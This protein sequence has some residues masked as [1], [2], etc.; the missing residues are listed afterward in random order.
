MPLVRSLNKF[1]YTCMVLSTLISS[2]YAQSTPPTE[3]LIADLTEIRARGVL[4]VLVEQDRNTYFVVRNQ[5]VGLENARI[6]AFVDFLNSQAPE[7]TPPMRLEIIPLPSGVLLEALA[8]GQ[9]DLAVS[10]TPLAISSQPNLVA[11]QAI[12]SQEPLVLVRYR[13]TSRLNRLEQLSGRTLLV[14]PD[15]SALPAITALNARLNAAK[16]P[17][18]MLD[19]ADPSLGTEDLLEM[20]AAGIYP[21]A[22][23]PLSL[24]KRWVALYRGLR[25]EDSLVFDRL[26]KFWILPKAAPNLLAQS[27][28]LLDN[29]VRKQNQAAAFKRTYQNQYRIHNPTLLQQSAASYQLD[30]LLAALAY[31][32]SGLNPKA[33][34][35]SVAT[36]LMQ[37]TPIVTRAVGVRNINTL[38]SN[39]EA[40]S[41]YLAMLRDRFFSDPLLTEA[42]ASHATARQRARTQ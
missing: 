3:Q 26:D 42:G 21:R 27:N 20:V 12:H 28:L 36:G 32:A 24:A 31:K 4:R 19:L 8:Q 18:I 11:T 39:I 10:S 1:L 38:A 6:Q 14:P 9:G 15:S 7:A 34:N 29:F 23:V 16:K 41:K 40:A 37:V 22:V 2:T 13:N 35:N 30:W 25:I 5:A 33:H 17:R